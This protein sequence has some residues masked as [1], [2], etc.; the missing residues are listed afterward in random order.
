[1]KLALSLLVMVLALIGLVL[2]LKPE[3][4]KKPRPSLK[5]KSPATPLPPAKEEKKFL[6]QPTPS[7]KNSLP[8]E[9]T[10]TE[11]RF[12]VRKYVNKFPGVTA[13]VMQDWMKKRP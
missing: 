4:K 2:V 3:K 9:P 8:R 1:M 10:M 13:D 6:T 5:G 12:A 7:D 11:I